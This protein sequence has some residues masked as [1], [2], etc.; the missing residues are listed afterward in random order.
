MGKGPPSFPA[1]FG[2][3]S[4][5]TARK[6]ERTRRRILEAAGCLFRERGVRG[7]TMRAIAA[8]AG[9]QAGSIYYHFSSKEEILEEI[10]DRGTR[11]AIR[12]LE[13]ALAGD[14]GKSCRARMELAI[15]AHLGAVLEHSLETGAEARLYAELPEA[16]RRRQRARRRHYGKLWD[17]LLSEAQTCGE[18]HP[19]VA[20]LPLRF[21]LLGALNSTAQWYPRGRIDPDRFADF[22]V[23]FLFDGIGAPPRDGRRAAD[24][25]LIRHPEEPPLLTGAA[26]G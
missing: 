2:D 26:S 16:L 7:T 21:L 1:T 10:L 18:I 23:R 15:R 14:D 17:R 22:L 9:M 12:A 25:R 3:S 4:I 13:A 19:E 24:H 5:V 8:A 20:L 11:A 6:A